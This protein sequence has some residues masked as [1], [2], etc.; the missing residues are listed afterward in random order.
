LSNN[1][2]LQKLKIALSLTSDDMLDLFNSINRDLSK[3][4]LSAFFRH[5]NH[6]SYRPCLDQYLRNFLG[7]LHARLA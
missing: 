1:M 7:A 5:P 2:I 4:E 6:R 3:H